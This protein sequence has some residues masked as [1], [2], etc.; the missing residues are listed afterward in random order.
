MN[1]KTVRIAIGLMLILSGLVWF[2]QGIGV[3]PGSGMSGQIEWAGY[4]GLAILSGMGLIYWINR[5]K[6]G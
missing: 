2:L 5:P 4:G 1:R 6:N 3:L